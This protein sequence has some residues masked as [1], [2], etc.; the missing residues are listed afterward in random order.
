M[1]HIPYGRQDISED[2][3]AAVIQTLRSD[4][5]TQ[6]PAI[7]EFENALAQYTGAR[8]AVAVSNATAALHIGCLAFGIGPGD[9]VWTA[10][11]SFVASA[12]CALYCG[13]EVDFVD[14]DPRSYNLSVEAL[15]EKLVAA[16]RAGKLPKLVIPV[17]F[18]GQSCDME[19]IS[20]LAKRYGFGLME[21]ASHAV[22][23]SYGG[24][25]VGAGVFSDLTVF[26]FHPVKIFTT[27][28][29]G[30]LLTNDERL[31]QRLLRLRS[32]G[33]TRDP[34]SMR[35]PSQGDW[36]YQ[37][38]EL[39]FNYRLTDIQATLGISQAK[40]L[41]EFVARRRALAVRYDRAL[42]SLPLTLP[43][44]DPEAVSAFHLYVI[45]VEESA[46]KGRKE[47]FDFLRS[48][49]VGVN[50]HYIPIHLQ[51]FYADKGFRA[52]QCPVAEAYYERAISIPMYSSLT[53]KDQDRVIALLKEILPS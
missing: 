14:I 27:A 18:A 13:A 34:A 42:A 39:G 47:V 9:L 25:K 44:Q 41:D 20:E 45:Q 23:G 11:N 2:D 38:I 24:R 40:R 35:G 53:E 22:G 52:G 21:D 51:P 10:S 32:H 31:Y 36:Y 26:S 46:G 5:L 15:E 30:M 43:W 6:G 3:I 49:G 12:N 37:Q 1:S 28:E 7:A 17:H 29:G 48:K 19:R 50:V 4:W 8:Y 33:I 16:K